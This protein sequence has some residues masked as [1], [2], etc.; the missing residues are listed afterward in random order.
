MNVSDCDTVDTSGIQRL[1]HIHASELRPFIGR[2]VQG[3]SL[4]GGT[5]GHLQDVNDRGEAVLINGFGT[6]VHPVDG[7]WWCVHPGTFTLNGAP[8]RQPKV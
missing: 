6:V 2:H 8:I 7:F 1:G 5:A 4:S 3:I